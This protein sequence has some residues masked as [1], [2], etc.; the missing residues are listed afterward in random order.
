MGS[1]VAPGQRLGG[2][3]RVLSGDI[4]PCLC[5]CWLLYSCC[6][7]WA[8]QCTAHFL[9]KLILTGQTDDTRMKIRIMNAL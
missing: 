8:P 6:G 4:W 7:P 9:F 2:C 1:I 3:G 5:S